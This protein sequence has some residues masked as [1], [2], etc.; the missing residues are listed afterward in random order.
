MQPN[1]TYYFV[2]NSTDKAGNSAQSTE[3]SFK[4][5]ELSNIVYV[6]RDGTGDY[7]CDGKDDQI[8]INQAIA[9]INSIGGGI[10]HLKNG[11]FVISDSINLTSNLILSLIHI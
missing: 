11:T 9:Y 5:K 7:N 1:T 8:E 4:T 2:V 3:Q 10:V 6:A